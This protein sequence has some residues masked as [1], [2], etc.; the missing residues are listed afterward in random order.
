M[1]IKRKLDGTVDEP[2]GN[3]R[4]HKSDVILHKIW[5]PAPSPTRSYGRQAGCAANKN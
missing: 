4:I 5:R 3:K 1:M 2:L